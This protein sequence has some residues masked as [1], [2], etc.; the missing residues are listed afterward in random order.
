MATV[1]WLTALVLSTS[2]FA[3]QANDNPAC[4]QKAAQIQ[5][6]IDYAKQHGNTR[7]QQGL[8]T[9]LENV[10]L[11]CTDAKLIRDKQEEI[12]EQQED[13]QDIQADIQEKRQEG[14]ADKVA[15][16]ERKLAKETAE[17]QKLQEE[18]QALQ[19][20]RGTP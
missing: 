17:L 15:K 5:L 18:L 6:Q 16:L 2:A 11:H 8:E 19:S 10:R 14:K 20:L 9:A 4:A 13:L 7:Q 3:A 1:H 12:A